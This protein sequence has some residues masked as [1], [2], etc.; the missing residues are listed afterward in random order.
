MKKRK[1][2]GCI[3]N[4]PENIYQSRILDGLLNRCDQYG[5]DLAVFSPLVNSSHFY[6]DYMHAEFNILELINFDL[7]DAL[8]VVSLPMITMADTT[9]FD[10][11]HDL[12]KHRCNKPVI[13]LDLPMGDY[14]TVYT[15]DTA[16]F[17]MITKH[18]LDVHKCKNV[19]FLAGAQREGV[20]DKRLKG[21]RE[22]CESRN[23]KIEENKIFY[24][25]FW[26]SSGAS[27]AERIVSGELEMPDAVICGSDHMALGLVNKLTELGVSVPGQVIVTG[28]DA[29][30]EALVNELSVTTF[31]PD[32]K[33]MAFEAIDRIR[34][35]LEPD[36]EI[37][38]SAEG[39]GISDNFVVGHSCGCELDYKRL[40][41]SLSSSL[42]RPNRDYDNDSIKDNED[43][44]HLM[45]SYMLEALTETKSPE[46]C[47][48]K[49]NGQTYLIRPYDFFYLCLRRNWL[50][51]DDPLIDGYPETM[52]TN[53]FKVLEDRPDLGL[54]SC[55]C[56][57]DR[58]AFN[59]KLMLPAL[60]EE[61]EKPQVF[62]FFPVHFQ[63]NTL[64][65][66]VLQVDS[67]K[68]IKP[69]N[70]MRNWMRNVNNAL[71]MTR[72]NNR[73]VDF[74]EID[75][76]TGLKNRRGME[77]GIKELVAS[78]EEN[79]YCYAIVFDLDGLKNINDNYGHTEGDYAIK[80]IASAV[81]KIADHEHEVAVRAGGD[82]FYL[83]GVNPHI[84]E[85]TLIAKVSTY[86][87]I[88]EEFNNSSNKPYEIS[89]SV[90]FSLRKLVTPDDID[91]AVN[92][93]DKH[94]YLC[95]AESKRGR[96]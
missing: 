42:Y 94:M 91:K 3:L 62:Y 89:A 71:E 28:F 8:V 37:Y 45:E 59:T 12:L 26:Y 77:N 20:E 19:Y 17:R 51:T 48:G 13:C 52:R 33:G 40:I 84:T 57:D 25:D 22:E 61:H 34:K 35:I 50:D 60:F 93:A 67:E 31:A 44:Y 88:V 74:S 72:V 29:T 9:V 32:N 81:A 65:Y 95:K 18:I 76:L 96:R 36:K 58:A 15:D 1:L 30:Q 85:K 63:K 73:L 66:A 2:I 21:Y 47:L 11:V 68:G 39:T 69:T 90:G 80:S 64:G 43:L 10:N 75:K 83:I 23:I 4:C 38:S 87:S 82:E 5:Y 53:A 41:N 92:S 6:K 86:R 78:A 16:A 7:I 49:I 14:E 55:H 56:D 54:I 79:S 46:E 27:L 24:G 70:V